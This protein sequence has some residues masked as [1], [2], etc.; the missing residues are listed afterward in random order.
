MQFR[1]NETAQRFEAVIEDRVVGFAEYRPA[2][3][4]LMFT[5]TEV[6]EALEGQGVGG[7][8]VRYSLEDA[9]A[10]GVGVVPMCPF[11]VTYLKRHPEYQNLVPEAHR[12]VFGL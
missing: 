3:Q 1:N 11:Y 10:R 5:H 12:H 2:G 7:A 9:R 6:N 8:L 4:H